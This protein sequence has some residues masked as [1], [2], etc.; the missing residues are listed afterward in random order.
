MSGGGGVFPTPGFAM[1]TLSYVLY[2]NKKSF[3]PVLDWASKFV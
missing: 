1:K 2:W 3:N